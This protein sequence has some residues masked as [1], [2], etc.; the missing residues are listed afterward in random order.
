MSTCKVFTIES[1]L[2]SSEFPI[3]ISPVIMRA[4]FRLEQA[5]QP[6]KKSV[7]QT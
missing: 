6:L 1:S 5:C 3:S 7:D 4:L 2:V